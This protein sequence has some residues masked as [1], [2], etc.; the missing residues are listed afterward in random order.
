METEG[1]TVTMSGNANMDFNDMDF[2][3]QGGQLILRSNADLD[4]VNSVFNITNGVLLSRNNVTMDLVNTPMT[5]QASSTG[6]TIDAYDESYFTFTNSPLLMISGFVKFNDNSTLEFTD[7]GTTLTIKFGDFIFRDNS[8][9]LTVQGTLIDIIE[10]GNFEMYDFVDIFF[11]QVNTTVSSS[12][13]LS[14]FSSLHALDSFFDIS[15]SFDIELSTNFTMV[16]SLLDV[17]GNVRTFH[18]S[19]FQA[20]DSDINVIENVIFRGDADSTHYIESSRITITE[21]GDF[22]IFEEVSATACQFVL[23]VFVQLGRN[24]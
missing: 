4:Y 11:D 1:S 3:V 23:C 2:V 10:E 14:D 7:P 15:G 16:S 6:Q 8:N 13:L 9:F 17:T 21:D 19:A 22:L 5:I 12:V 20:Y 18:S 24:Y